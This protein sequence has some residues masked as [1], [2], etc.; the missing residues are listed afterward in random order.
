MRMR[1]PRHHCPRLLGSIALVC[2]SAGLFVVATATP[3]A[4][5]PRC[6]TT[7]DAHIVVSSEAHRLWLCAGYRE[8]KSYWVRLA[9]NETG[10]RQAGDAMLPLGS[11]VLGAPRESKKF[12]LFIPIGYPSPQ[13]AAQGYTG[14]SVGIHGPHRAV[15]WLGY[16][17]NAF[18]TTAGCVGV[19]TD[20]DMR[21]IAGFASQQR[22]R[23]I[24]IR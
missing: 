19:A 17:V 18:D 10:K 14:D 4:A 22:A 23:W 1:A 5:F 11:Y 24:T 16:L 15:R 2:L 12:G 6:E 3:V 9:R 7:P 8:V 20:G 21:E 13:Q